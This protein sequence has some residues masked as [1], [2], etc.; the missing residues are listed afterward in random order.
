[1]L[2]EALHADPYSPWLN[3]RLAWAYH[4]SGEAAKSVVQTEHAL[5]IF[6]DHESSN[7][8]GSI[9]LAFNGNADRAIALAE[10]LVRRSPYFDPAIA[11]HGYALAH[12][13]PHRRSALHPRTAAM[14]EPRTFRLEFLHCSPSA[15][16]WETSK[17]PSLNCTPPP[18][19]DVHGFSRCSR[20]RGLNRC[21]AIPNSPE[22]Q[23]ILERME[24]AAE[25]KPEPDTLGSSASERTAVE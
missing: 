20:I 15:S 7:I 19:P 3:A 14:A 9:I 13:R 4:L 23:R 1:M 17:A 16:P 6:P 18:N 24:N 11:V 8:Y 5:E 12:G 21:A 10:N 25:K 22:W 2:D